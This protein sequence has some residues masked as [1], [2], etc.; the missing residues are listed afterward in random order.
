MSDLPSLSSSEWQPTTCWCEDPAPLGYLQ[1]VLCMIIQPETKNINN[2][3]GFN[4]SHFTG[5]LF[6][7]IRRLQS[8][9]FEVMRTM[10][11]WRTGFTGS[12]NSTTSSSSISTTSISIGSNLSTSTLSPTT[13]LLALLVGFTG[14]SAHRKAWTQKKVQHKKRLNMLL[15]YKIYFPRIRESPRAKTCQADL[16]QIIQIWG[17]FTCKRNFLVIVPGLAFMSCDEFHFMVG[18]GTCSRCK[19]VCAIHYLPPCTSHLSFDMPCH[20]WY[21]Y[22]VDIDMAFIF[23]LISICYLLASCTMRI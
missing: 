8:L 13:T 22:L 16:L 7:D 12:S 15:R 6:W 2:S 5:Y 23:I 11:P 4:V 20:C 17:G 19:W 1:F 14:C 10:V 18:T 3:I 21:W 9:S